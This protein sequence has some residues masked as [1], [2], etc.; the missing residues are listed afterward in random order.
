MN[1][2]YKQIGCVV[3][4]ACA[5]LSSLVCDETTNAQTGNKEKNTKETEQSLSLYKSERL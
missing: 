3:V 2:L 4:S 1:G 5:A